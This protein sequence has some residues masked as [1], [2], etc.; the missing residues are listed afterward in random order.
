MRTI[1]KNTKY[2][3]IYTCKEIVID[4]GVPIIVDKELFDRVQERL[5]ANRRAPAHCK[6]T[7]DYLLSG[8]LYCGKCSAGMV[9][10]SGTGKHGEKHHYYICVNKKR[11]KTCD[12]KTV[13]KDWLENLVIEET[14]NHV[15]QPDKMKAIAEKCIEVY[16]K[17]TSRNDELLHLQK[18]LAETKKSIKN[19]MTAIEQGII[20]RTTQARLGELEIAEDNLEYEIEFAKIKQPTLTVEQITL[21]LSQFQR[22]STDDSVVSVN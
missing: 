5:A 17:D 6:G 18:Q 4:G 13:R 10:E 21:M 20:L 15:L 8:K 11:S 16:K 1:L 2:I 3:G 12:K 22:E 19:L 9:G 14:V 7:V